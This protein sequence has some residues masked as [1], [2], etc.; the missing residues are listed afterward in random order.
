MKYK[1]SVE[2]RNY[3]N[4]HK[5]LQT[6]AV[7]P[8]L[9]SF[10]NKP[11]SRI[12]WALKKG[13]SYEKVIDNFIPLCSSCH[14]AYDNRIEHLSRVKHKKVVALSEGVELRFVSIKQAIEKT[15]VLG[16]SI[17][18]NLSGR[19]KSAGGFKWYYIN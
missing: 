7:K 10:C 16:T 3:M 1:H 18:N 13:K 17:S 8:N 5:W 11:G 4:V 14:T 15:G 2:K 19:S 9:C 6:N 12:E